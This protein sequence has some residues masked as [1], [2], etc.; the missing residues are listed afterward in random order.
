MNRIA[1]NSSTFGD[2]E[3]D[4]VLEVM[5]SSRVTMDGK[6]HEFELAF[7]EY[8][9]GAEA[10]FVNSGSSANLLGFFAL[11]N[12]TAPRPRD[13]RTTVRACPA[14]RPRE[15]AVLSYIQNHRRTVGG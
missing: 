12:H 7:G 3:T 13:K 8:V 5:K 14:G 15:T 10:I 1:L 2:E 6:C 11:A 9:G 4:A